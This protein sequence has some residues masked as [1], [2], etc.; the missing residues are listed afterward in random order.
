MVSVA[1]VGRATG[2]HDLMRL[3]LEAAVEFDRLKRGKDVDEEVIEAFTEC[4][5]GTNGGAHLG[6]SLYLNHGPRTLDAY[7]RAWRSIS[8]SRSASLQ[9]QKA[10][11]VQLLGD[12]RSAASDPNLVVHN[13]ILQEKVATLEKYCLALHQA[14]LA[15]R[16]SRRRSRRVLDVEGVRSG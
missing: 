15:E 2:K 5:S 1:E 12:V 11:V 8:A 6:G 3:S 14:L 7:Y 16:P 9:A 4:L 13:N 10:K